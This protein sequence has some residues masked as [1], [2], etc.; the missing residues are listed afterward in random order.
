VAGGVHQDEGGSASPRG[1]GPAA[2]AARGIRWWVTASHHCSLSSDD[3]GRS[4]ASISR[5]L[6]CGQRFPCLLNRAQGS[7]VEGAAPQ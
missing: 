4:R 2:T 1:A 5:L 3:A 7:A 6:Q